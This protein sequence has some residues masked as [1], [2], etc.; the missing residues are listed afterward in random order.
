MPLRQGLLGNAGFGGDVA[1]RPAGIEPLT[2]A[3][4]ALRGQRG[5]TVGHEG[6]LVVGVVFSRFA[7]HQ[8]ALACPSNR[9]SRPVI[10]VPEYNT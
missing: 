9:L 8:E 2:Q 7:P 10:N 1:D 4:T 5:V 6:L 3:P